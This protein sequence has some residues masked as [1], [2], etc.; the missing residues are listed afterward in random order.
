MIRPAVVAAV[1]L[2]A[3]YNPDLKSGRLLCDPPGDVCPGGYHCAFDGTC[4]QDGQDPPFT[5]PSAPLQVQATSALRSAQ[6]IWFPPLDEGGKPVTSYL[7]TASP[8]G[9]TAQVSEPQLTTQATV[10][11]LEDATT[12]TFTVQAQN[13]VGLSPASLPSGAVQTPGL[14]GQ[15]AG[16]A[17]TAAKQSATVTWTAPP[18]GGTPIL[19]YRVVANPPGAAATVSGNSATL[20]LLQDGTSYTFTVFAHNAVGDGPVSAPSAAVTPAP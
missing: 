8:G 18:S 6:V 7:V 13:S 16:V 10:F 15:P 20:F 4:W 2:C 3:C 14:P 17:G 1:A 5:A 19:W 12:Y 9:A 11:G